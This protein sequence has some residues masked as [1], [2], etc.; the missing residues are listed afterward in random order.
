[1]TAGREGILVVDR[2]VIFIYRCFMQEQ[3][4]E[5][6]FRGIIHNAIRGFGGNL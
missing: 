5:E 6:Y 4:I 2:R 1:M 3:V